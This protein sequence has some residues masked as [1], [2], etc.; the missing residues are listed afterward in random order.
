MTVA[1]ERV[2]VLVE[3]AKATAVDEPDLASTYVQLARRVAERYRVELPREFRWFTCTTCDAY[4]RPGVNATV[5]LQNGHVT[6]TC[7]CGAMDRHPYE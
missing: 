2:G 1:D 7:A 3:L 6:I 4:L 5:R